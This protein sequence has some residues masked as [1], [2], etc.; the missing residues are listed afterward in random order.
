MSNNNARLR[1]MVVGFN[2]G[3]RQ[4]G[5]LLHKPQTVELTDDDLDLI[6][7]IA[8][9][10]ATMPTPPVGPSPSMGK[11]VT[12]SPQLCWSAE[13]PDGLSGNDPN[14]RYIPGQGVVRV[15]PLPRSNRGLR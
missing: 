13:N 12:Q 3:A 15:T 8:D 2:T 5:S 9:V 10:A 11:S 6:E 4:S 14:V 1:G 7:A